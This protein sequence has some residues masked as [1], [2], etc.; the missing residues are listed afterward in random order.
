MTPS[1]SSP[2]NHRIL[3]AYLVLAVNL[4]IF[5][6]LARAGYRALARPKPPAAPPAPPARPLLKHHRRNS[7][8]TMEMMMDGVDIPDRDSRDSDVN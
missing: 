4:V 7:S 3:R 2:N 6:M 1:S 8:M 5:L